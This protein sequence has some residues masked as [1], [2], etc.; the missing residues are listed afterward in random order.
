M[1]PFKTFYLHYIIVVLSN[2]LLANIGKGQEPSQIAEYTKL[3]S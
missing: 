1:V 3:E 2:L